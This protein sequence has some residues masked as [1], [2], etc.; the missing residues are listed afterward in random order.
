METPA[1]IRILQRA[2]VLAGLLAGAAISAAGQPAPYAKRIGRVYRT[3]VPL[4]L[5]ESEALP[6]FVYLCG[7]HA[8][9]PGHFREVVPAGARL[10]LLAETHD[11]CRSSGAQIGFL[12]DLRY[13]PHEVKIVNTEFIQTRARVADGRA[14]PDIDPRL[15]LP[16]A[17]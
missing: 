15:A 3:T 11:V 6:H 1:R 7:T 4:D 9:G 2:L 10:R 13:G 16:P 17:S 12:C 8:R 5:F 14:D